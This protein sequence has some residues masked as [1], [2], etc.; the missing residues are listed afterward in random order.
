MPSGV[1]DCWRT[2]RA[3]WCAV[4][5]ALAILLWQVRRVR[6]ARKAA[7]KANSAKSEFLANMSHEIRTP[8]NG[9]VGMAELLARTNLDAEQ[10][11]M[12]GVIR[13][14]SETLTSIVDDILDFSKIEAGGLPVEPVP[15]D[16]HASVVGVVQLFAPRAHSKGLGFETEIAPDVPRLV[17]G[18]P[19]RIQQVLTNLLANALKF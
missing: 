3:G 8:L 15:F 19:L 17:K 1:L 14:S 12:A 11:E 10:R 5:G 13:S 7:E 16:L 4:V 2:G 18:D 6:Q 9:I